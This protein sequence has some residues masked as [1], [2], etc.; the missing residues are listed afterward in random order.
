MEVQQAS[1]VWPERG[2]AAGV[3]DAEGGHEGYAAQPLVEEGVDGEKRG[4][5]VERIDLGLD[6]EHVHAAVQESARL[7]AVG[8]GQIIEGDGPESRVAYVG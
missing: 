2:A 7:L 5:Q 4:L 6:Q 3:D 1:T 8:F